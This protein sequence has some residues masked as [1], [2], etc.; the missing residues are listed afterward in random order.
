MIKYF[1]DS[2]L[3][4]VK[5]VCGGIHTVALTED[6]RVFTWGTNDEFALGRTGTENIP[7]EVTLP[8][9]AEINGISAGDSH[10]VAYSTVTN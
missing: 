8:A 3:N 4:V 1:E 7:G 9:K 5:V 10:S 6:G 2:K